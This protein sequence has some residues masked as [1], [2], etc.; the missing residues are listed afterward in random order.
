MADASGV[1]VLPSFLLPPSL[2]PSVSR[3]FSAVT[4]VAMY[5]AALLLLLSPL[6]ASPHRRHHPRIVVRRGDVPRVEMDELAGPMALGTDGL[7]YVRGRNLFR[8]NSWLHEEVFSDCKSFTSSCQNVVLMKTGRGQHP[9]YICTTEANMFRCCDVTS[10]GSAA[11]CVEHQGT[12]IDEDDPSLLVGDQLYATRSGVGDG[13]GIQRF[14]RNELWQQNNHIEHRYV[15]LFERKQET[16]PLQNKIFAFYN[17]KNS[18]QNLASHL[19]IPCVSQVCESDLGGRKDHMQYSWTSQLKARLFCGDCEKK[20]HFTELLDVALL[21]TEEQTRVYGLFKNGWEMRAVCVYTMDDIDRVFTSSAVKGQSGP[22]PVERP[23]ECVADSNKLSPEVLKVMKNHPEMEDWVM[24]L[25][26]QYLLLTKHRNYSRIQVD[27][28]KGRGNKFHTVLLLALEHGE[29]HKVLESYSPS[30][31]AEPF[32]IAGF[33]AFNGTAIDSMLLNFFSKRL[34]LR[35]GSEVAMIDLQNCALYGSTCQNCIMARDPYCGWDQWTQSAAA[36]KH[37]MVQDVENGNAAVC[38]SAD[39]VNSHLSSPHDDPLT[40]IAQFSQAYLQCQVHS[41]HATYKWVKYNQHR[42]MPSIF[43]KDKIIM[44]IDSMSE[45]YEGKYQCR[46]SENG[47]NWTVVA[48][49]V[50]MKS[51]VTAT[52]GCPALLGWTLLMIFLLL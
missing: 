41:W 21:E 50:K 18:D 27:R 5:P 3:L 9:I 37:N 40:E 45:D 23:G 26:R 7:V 17:E 11:N 39:A 48:Y 16:N 44:F 25:D 36:V 2:L 24:P 20:L 12:A 10:N 43:D 42:E 22:K 51:G 15:K 30:G 14:F 32:Y 33:Q 1:T 28:A 31:S 13:V 46:A 34:Y 8:L 49:Q 6:L 38:T 19:W 52:N 29:V 4:P 35:S 47:Y